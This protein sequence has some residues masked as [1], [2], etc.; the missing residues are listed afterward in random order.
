MPAKNYAVRVNDPDKEVCIT[1]NAGNANLVQAKM[2]V[3]QKEKT[4]DTDNQPLQQDKPFKLGIGKQ[5]KGKQVILLAT[6]A[7]NPAV[8]NKELIFSFSLVNAKQLGNAKQT[9]NS[10]DFSNGSDLFEVIITII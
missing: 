3:N 7:P 1:Y 6:L 10:K 5:I 2:K 4:T 8:N 9:L